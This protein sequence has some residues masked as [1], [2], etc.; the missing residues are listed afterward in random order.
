MKSPSN[1]DETLG[2]NKT[3]NEQ[4]KV[5]QTINDALDQSIEQLSTSTLSD[6][7]QVRLQAL[8][9]LNA[10]NSKESLFD[11]VKKWLAMPSITFGVP[12]ALAIMITVSV[13]YTGVESIPELPLAMMITEVPNEDFAMLEEL[14][15]VAW[16]AE[17]EQSILL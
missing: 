8:K 5:E 15:F 6:I 13:K 3:K 14:E 17:N 2:L 7:A 10:R 11:I 4:D 1:S 9:H 16:L 12:A